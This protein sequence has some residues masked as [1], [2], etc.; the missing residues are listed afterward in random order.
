MTE[1]ENPYEVMEAA[2]LEQH[3]GQ[4]NKVMETKS[5]SKLQFFGESISEETKGKLEEVASL[6]QKLT[7]AEAKIPA[8]VVSNPDVDK[9]ALSNL[10]RAVQ[11]VKAIDENIP[12][13][14]I[15]DSSLNSFDK[16]DML[17][18]VQQIAVYNKAALDAVTKELGAQ[19][20]GMQGF[21][22]P[23][24]NVGDADK[25]VESLI[26]ATGVKFE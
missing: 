14:G 25:L 2:V 12:I 11:D 4:I 1:K 24:V 22:K 10:D 16:A 26:A 8:T 21:S 13:Q 20:P 3:I 19:K 18:H 7:D 17:N 23:E 5:L 6:T 9:L 15:L